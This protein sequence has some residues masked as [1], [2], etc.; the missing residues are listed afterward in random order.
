MT[1]KRQPKSGLVVDKQQP[2]TTR[3]VRN[4]DRPGRPHPFGV[5]WREF[6][7]EKNQM[8]RKTEF[9]AKEAER[10]KRARDLVAMKREGFTSTMNREEIASWTAFQAATTGYSWRE[11]SDYRGAGKT[12]KSI[13]A[14]ALVGSI[15]FHPANRELEP[16]LHVHKIIQA[17]CFCEERGG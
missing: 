3:G 14:P 17:L 6:D 5:Q 2:T 12:P 15:F 4:I 16:D 13:L 7:E 11:V 10:D 1:T 9:F 8:G